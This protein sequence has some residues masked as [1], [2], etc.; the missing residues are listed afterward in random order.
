MMNADE[1]VLLLGADDGWGAGGL[2]ALGE[3]IVGGEGGGGGIE[4]IGKDAVEREVGD[5]G[6]AV[7]W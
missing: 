1:T 7:V 5:P 4:A 2:L 3:P 6:E